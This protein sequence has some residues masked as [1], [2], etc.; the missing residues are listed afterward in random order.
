MADGFKSPSSYC[1]LLCTHRPHEPPLTAHSPAFST[2]CVW[3]LWLSLAWQVQETSHEPP[4]DAHLAFLAGAS[5][6]LRP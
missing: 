2:V 3:E 5:L 4:L 1:A 6:L